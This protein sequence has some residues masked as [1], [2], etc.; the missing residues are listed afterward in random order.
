MR[1]LGK[2]RKLILIISMPVFFMALI[3]GYDHFW[4]N[5]RSEEF[6]DQW[7]SRFSKCPDLASVTQNYPKIYIRKFENGDW[8][9]IVHEY[10]CMDGAGYDVSVFYDST[11]AIRY[12]KGCNFCGY[13]GL[14]CEMNRIEAQSLR[15][16]YS[17]L[18]FLNLR[19]R[20][21]GNEDA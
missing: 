21:R 9:A 10:S 8:L 20:P 17:K 18:S 4:R 11:G 16:F 3:Y 12:D 5:Y 7:S 14:C 6:V 19:T 2:K 1:K 13:E 15:E